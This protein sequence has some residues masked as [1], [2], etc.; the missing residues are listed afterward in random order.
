MAPL[1]SAFNI[2]ALEKLPGANHFRTRFPIYL[3][4]YGFALSHTMCLAL[5]DLI[6]YLCHATSPIP[7]YLLYNVLPCSFDA[8]FFWC[9]FIPCYVALVWTAVLLLCPSFISCHLVF[10]PWHFLW[11]YVA[12]YLY[13]ILSHPSIV[14]LHSGF[15]PLFHCVAFNGTLL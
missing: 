12:L 14:S 6:H 4:A 15:L 9:H 5:C 1:R 7:C 2:P 10:L 3:I 8:A 13:F 11:R